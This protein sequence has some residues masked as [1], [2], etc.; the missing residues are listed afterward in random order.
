MAFRTEKEVLQAKYLLGDLSEQEKVTIEESYFADDNS[1][2][3]LEIIEDELV[4][5]YV[6]DELPAA[7]R[8]QFE[9]LLQ[10][11]AR[12]SGR[13]QFARILSQP[14]PRTGVLPVTD[15]GDDVVVERSVRAQD[16]QTLVAE[17]L[18]GAPTR[19]HACICRSR[20]HCLARNRF[21]VHMVTVTPDIPTT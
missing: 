2:G 19:R 15:A 20:I 4:D 16:N 1:F 18:C 6:H 17:D 21:A 10:S 12:L 9:K 5:A 13:V 8:Q 7:E 14:C 11:S 3:E